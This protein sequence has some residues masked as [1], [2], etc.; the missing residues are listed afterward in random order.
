MITEP[1]S[2]KVALIFIILGNK[3]IILVKQFLK[4]FTLIKKLYK[5]LHRKFYS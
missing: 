4:L 2:S 5:H 3:I 1:S